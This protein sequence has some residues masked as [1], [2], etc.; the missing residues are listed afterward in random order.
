MASSNKRVRAES[1]TDGPQH[2][3][4]KHR[5]STS[6]L[7]GGSSAVASSSKQVKKILLFGHTDADFHR[8]FDHAE[9]THRKKGPF[10]LLFAVGRVRKSGAESA[11]KIG[12]DALLSLHQQAT[13]NHPHRRSSTWWAYPSRCYFG[14][15]RKRRVTADLNNTSG[16]NIYIC[17]LLAAFLNFQFLLFLIGAHLIDCLI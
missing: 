16:N 12:R 14:L 9:E 10:N 8:L 5:A 13:S 2:Q 11:L 6:T 4:K 17:L 1:A 15:S 7:L 3:L